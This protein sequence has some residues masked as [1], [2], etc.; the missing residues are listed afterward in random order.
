VETL[1]ALILWLE[2]SDQASSL[3]E[4]AGGL[5]S[6][7]VARRAAR[8]V[9]K[10]GPSAKSFSGL[11][12]PWLPGYWSELKKA[13]KEKRPVAHDVSF[14]RSLDAAHKVVR[15][16]HGMELG[17]RL[18]A[19]R[20]GAAFEHAGRP[21][22]VVK[23]DRGDREARLARYASSSKQLKKNS[24]LPTYHKVVNTGVKDEKTGEHIHALHR[25]DLSDLK[26]KRHAAWH[27][28]GLSVS[29][30]AE[31]LANSGE[32]HHDFHALKDELDGHHRK[33]REHV[34][35]KEKQSFDR[36]HK[37]VQKLVRHGI[38]PCDMHADN[39]GTRKN[40]DVVLRDAGCHHRVQ[41][42]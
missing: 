7:A 26:T 33:L 14:D 6:G 22:T 27:S 20:S 31:R 25:E 28:Y 8:T 36:F 41:Y 40:G 10:I 39:L 11:K 3:T 12:P 19:G 35:E 13:K 2:A 16:K 1:S 29:G 21:G 32:T 23:F 34:P 18:G 9:R 42:H 37:G 38:V 15:E 30:T 5:P 17:A 4:V 24:I